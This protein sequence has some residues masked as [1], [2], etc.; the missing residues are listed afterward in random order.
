MGHYV[1]NFTVYTLA[2]SG[3]IFF[4][5][6]VYKKIMQGGIRI[7][8]SNNISIEETFSINPRK[9]LI[10]VRVNNERF[11]LASDIDK[12]TLISKLEDDSVIKESNAESVSNKENSDLQEIYPIVSESFTDYM[13]ILEN[14]KI[15]QPE[16]RTRQKEKQPVHLEIIKDKNPNSV[17]KKSQYSSQNLNNTKI[18]KVDNTYKQSE[19]PIKGIVQKVNNI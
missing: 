5:F 9:S 6:F 17:R 15:V 10:V 16:K 12:T 19:S 14:A 3:L 13:S 4:A 18:I 1:I 7:Q 8:K 11:L 2:M